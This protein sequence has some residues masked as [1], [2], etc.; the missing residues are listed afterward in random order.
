MKSIRTLVL[1][2]LLC[3]LAVWS[4]GCAE[5]NLPA[6]YVMVQD[7]LFTLEGSHA[8]ELP[9]GYVQIG[10]VKGS[11]VPASGEAEEWESLGCDAGD[12]IYQD[13]ACPDEV[14]VYTALFAGDDE[15][16]YLKFHRF[17]T[18]GTTGTVPA[19]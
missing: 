6:P 11:V 7:V 17:T 14:Y 10:T 13:P 4:G 8:S 19:P 1:A 9:E 16:R 5:P 3:G 15:P 2:T 18:D 12:E